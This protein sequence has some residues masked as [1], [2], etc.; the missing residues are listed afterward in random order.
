[1]SENDIDIDQYMDSNSGHMK[2]EDMDVNS[3]QG[4]HSEAKVANNR[5]HD[6]H[7]VWSD[8]ESASSI[9]DDSEVDGSQDC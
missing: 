5:W 9:S 2:A 7:D 8:M 1:M 6:F 3:I 4:G